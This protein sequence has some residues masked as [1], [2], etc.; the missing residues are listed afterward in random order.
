MGRAAPFLLSLVPLAYLV[1]HALDYAVDLPVIDDW[2]LVPLLE[3]SYLG[4]LGFADFWAQHNE[5]RPIFPRLVML[6]VARLSGWNTAYALWSNLFFAL[7]TFCLLAYQVWRAGRRGASPGSSMWILPLISTLVF[8]TAQ[9]ENWFMVFTVQIFMNTC[10]VVAGAVLL[11]G[12]RFRWTRVGLAF[13]CGVVATYSWANGLLFWPVGFLALLLLGYRDSR[14]RLQVLAL[15]VAGSALVIAPYLVRYATPGQHPDPW[16]AFE[17][18]L[19]LWRYVSIYLNARILPPDRYPGRWGALGLLAFLALSVLSSRVGRRGVS[20]LSPFWVLGL[21]SILS[22]LVTAVGRVGFGV[23]QAH[24]SRYVTTAAPM[25]VALVVL[26][27]AVVERARARARVAGAVPAL[28]VAAG[29]VCLA[30]LA[31]PMARSF[32]RETEH[33]KPR[34]ETLV[35]IRAEAVWARGDNPFYTEGSTDDSLLPEPLVWRSALPILQRYRLSVYRDGAVA[36]P[37]LV[38]GLP[39]DAPLVVLSPRLRG[40]IRLEPDLRVPRPVESANGAGFLWL[41]EGPERGLSGRLFAETAREVMFELSLF[42]GSDSSGA[43]CTVHFVLRAGD[44][45]FTH[46][47]EFGA[48]FTTRVVAPVQPGYSEFEVYAT[49]GGSA[50]SAAG[51]APIRLVGLKRLYLRWVSPPE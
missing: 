23:E 19:D 36:Y 25:W 16:A 34:Y 49:A 33:F 37:H 17:R 40:A 1:K 48:A 39:A 9:W 42:P 6:A 5:H 43:P 18:P 26:L 7:V 46:S 29:L 20:S 50:A 28:Q 51:D 10:A 12:D 47:R 3:K 45:E 8:S 4:Q 30:G 24:A 15:W 44:S 38:S 35:P 11:G 31:L 13:L 2:C 14:Q 27:Y 22:A 21:Y 32:L 41:G